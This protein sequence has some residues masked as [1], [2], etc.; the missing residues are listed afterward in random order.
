MLL[1]ADLDIGEVA[2]LVDPGS[3]D[4]DIGGRE[5]S[6]GRHL[7]TSFGAGDAQD[8][9]AFRALA[10]HD[11][12]AV[13]T[14]AESILPLVQTESGLLLAR[15]VAAQAVGLEDRFDVAVEGGLNGR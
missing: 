11:D 6:S 9:F 10:G 12:R 7:H 8:Q 1:F 5:R 15:T 14:A 4:S 13:I 3:Q 2:A